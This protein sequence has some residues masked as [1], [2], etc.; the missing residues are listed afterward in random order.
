MIG[1]GLSI[2]G[3][4]LGTMSFY[5]PVSSGVSSIFL[6]VI[7]YVLGEGLSHILPRQGHIG[8]ILNPH[9]V[10]YNPGMTGLEF[11]RL[12]VQL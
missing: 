9:P 10:G 7:S 1:L 4:A 5:K 2:F 12:V 11:L 6:G 3:A 8:R